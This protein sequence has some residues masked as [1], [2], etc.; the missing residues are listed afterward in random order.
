MGRLIALS[1][2]I[3]A[4]CRSGQPSLD[5]DRA[6]AEEWVRTEQFRLVLDHADD[7]LRR[8][9]G[10]AKAQW[11]IRLAKAEA[12]LGQERPAEEALAL[13]DSHGNM[14]EGDG[15]A[16]YRARWFFLRARA[17]RSLGRRDAGELLD[18]AASAA[19]TANLPGLA[20]DVELRRAFLARDAGN[21]A[22]A[23]R[24][25]GDVREKARQMGDLSRQARAEN[26]EGDLLFS[27]SRYDESIPSFQA[28]RA[29]ALSANART[30]AA[31]AVGN[32]GAAWLRLGDYDNAR[33]CADTAEAEFERLGNLY[34]EQV[35]I[36][37]E[38][39]VDKELGNRQAA[40]NSYSRAVKISRMLQP[41]QWTGR[42][43]SNLATIS[44]EI[45]DWDSAERY[46]DEARKLKDRTNDAAYQASSLNNA[47][48]IA[49]GRGN[50]DAAQDL[51]ASALHRVS[52]DPT[53]GLEA[54][55]GLARVFA[56]RGSASAA[57]TEYR[58]TIA[59]I[60]DR[61]SKLV[62]D[63]YR[64]SWL[65]SLV[66]FY[67]AYVD[68]LIAQKQPE[69][70]LEAA[71]SS[72][73]KVLAAQPISPV[74]AAGYRKLAQRTGAA[75]LEYWLGPDHSYLWVVT[76][77]KIALHIL[78][79]KSEL[80]PLIRSYRAV[81]T[82]GRNPLNLAGDT[83]SQLYN[84]L[85]A[86]AI[87]DAGTATRFIVVPDDE[88]YSLNFETLPDGNN[89]NRFWIDR[90]TIRITP[91]LNYLATNT[92][93]VEKKPSPQLLLIGDPVAS[94][95]QY[96]H[97]E[98]AG[99]EISAVAE[100]MSAARPVI[101]R[102]ADATPQSYAA[103]EPGRFGFIHFSAHA[104][105]PAK[106]ES[107][108]DSSVILSGTPSQCRL[109]AHDVMSI[110]LQAEL[111]TVSACRSAGGRTYGGEG[112]VGF[113]WAF[114]K[115]G[116]GNV[117][118]GLWDV[119]DQST[120]LLMKGLYSEIARGAPVAEALRSAKLALIHGGGSYSRPYYWAP[121]E[122]YTARAD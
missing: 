104:A 53:A 96:P 16:E 87:A 45:R 40:I 122:I 7:W 119:N 89:A 21:R 91:S 83:G 86:P 82:K 117:I 39:N 67:Q 95:P 31:R 76:P 54:H 70:A 64:L 50:L 111:V 35:F 55:T 68:F 26:S 37:G 44:I 58:N 10:N 8:S 30:T 3:L 69:R 93:G 32:L 17:A 118:A 79:S 63:E 59:L 112:L 107:A 78:P 109:V 20:L 72:R 114:M 22:E 43:L 27:E 9:D 13:L 98:F 100:A 38:G 46:N 116:A 57:E 11:G 61:Q 106:R 33:A 115:A 75:L 103:H 47:G 94:L 4:G 97:L 71:E 51:F 101:V 120:V 108:L 25:F 5:A 29:L 62:K 84:A 41:T 23:H 36:G 121:F 34:E 19:G 85:I 66:R 74:A 105:A 28:S 60:E 12:L 65:A 90:A 88:L 24:I 99:R 56:L 42:W 113:A 92:G 48:D 6:Q 81:V 80:L 77:G 14:P 15:W 2:L 102:G 18:E 52:E 110:P 49:I 1:A 73:S